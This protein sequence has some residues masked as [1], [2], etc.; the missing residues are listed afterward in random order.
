[1]NSTPKVALVGCGGWGKNL[2]RNLSALDA[3]A[4]VVDPS[5][6]AA[7]IAQGLGAPV[8][9]LDAVLADASIEGVVI[10]TPA[11]THF[12][13]ASAALRAGKDVFVEKP[14]ALDMGDAEALEVLARDLG[15]VL[16]VGHLLQ[17]H[18]VFLDLLDRVRRGELGKVSHIVSSRL[19]FGVLRSYENVLWSFAPHDISMVLALADGIP[20]RVTAIGSTTLQPGIP[21]TTAL[22][23]RFP[24][25]A[26]ATITSSWLNPQKEQKLV[27]VGD[28]G[29]AVFDDRLPWAEKLALHRNSVDWS[30]G[31]PRAAA[32]EI[33]HPAIAQGEPLRD[34]MA[35]FLDAIRSRSAPRTDAAEAI[36]VLRVLRAAQES[37][38]HDGLPV[39]IAAA[40]RV[41]ESALS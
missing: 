13:V 33:E 6:A 27:V 15:R 41:P 11:P 39:D 16:M 38:D 20:A 7:A 1:M 2:A 28:R 34:E 8:H 18:A 9:T 19:N 4:A 26:T 31:A 30:T 14:I 36:G 25:G 24:G 17:Y 22:H 35:H 29:M 3:L 40:E 10:A 5:P 23:L 37:L 21:D 32:G 12:D